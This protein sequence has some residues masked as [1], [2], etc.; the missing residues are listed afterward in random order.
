LVVYLSTEFGS[1]PTSWA[2]L[3]PLSASLGLLDGRTP[4]RL[5]LLST[6]IVAITGAP[7]ALA[8]LRMRNPLT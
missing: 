4:L 3:L 1:V 5:P 2:D 8:S 6:A 7:A